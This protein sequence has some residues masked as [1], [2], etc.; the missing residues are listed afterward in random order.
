M[1]TMNRALLSYGVNALWQILLVAAA[2]AVA[3]RFLRHA[4][5]RY[6]YALW[7]AALITATVVPA[8]GIGGFNSTQR[9]PDLL[10]PARTLADSPSAPQPAHSQQTPP[11]HKPAAWTLSASWAEILRDAFLLWIAFAFV[12]LGVAASKTVR[13]R[14]RC[15]TTPASAQLTAAWNR[16]TESFPGSRAEILVSSALS[17]PVTIGSAVILPE[18]MLRESEDALAAALGHELA[19]VE[20]HDFVVNL[21]FEILALPISFHPAAFSSFAAASVKPAKW[22]A[23]NLSPRA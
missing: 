13:I 3:A 15:L 7:C 23:M 14:R 22:P 21:L 4:P 18:A 17:A 2:A 9:P 20:R 8:A 16:A 10:A 19:H 5:A 1:E 11:A 6:V 12:R